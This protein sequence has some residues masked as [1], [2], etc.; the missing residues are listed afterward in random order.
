M[1]KGDDLARMQQGAMHAH[2]PSHLLRAC[3]QL[4]DTWWGDNL[5]PLLMEAGAADACALS[6]KQLR[7]ICQRSVTWLRL[8]AAGLDDEQQQLQ[9]LGGLAALSCIPCRIPFCK[10]LGITLASREDA[11]F[12]LAETL[13]A[14]EE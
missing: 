11:A 10:Q 7:A 8:S 4:Q 13:S 3:K 6:C 5:L 1:M 12:Y 14:L 9:A 2:E